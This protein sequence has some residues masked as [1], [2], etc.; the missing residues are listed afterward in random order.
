LHPKNLD[1]SR[2]P[3]RIPERATNDRVSKTKMQSHLAIL[4]LR[5]GPG[6]PSA[7]KRN[8]K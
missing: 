5:Q 8:R 2:E 3:N 7:A 1:S 6:R 4:F